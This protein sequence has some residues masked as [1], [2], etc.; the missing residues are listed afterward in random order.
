MSELLQKTKITRLW[1]HVFWLQQGSSWL[2]SWYYILEFS[3]VAVADVRCKDVSQIHDSCAYDPLLELC[4]AG[5]F[6]NWL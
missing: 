4:S 5:V 6:F 1:S 2:G 3:L